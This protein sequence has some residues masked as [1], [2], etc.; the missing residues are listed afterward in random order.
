MADEIALLFA[1]ELRVELHAYTSLVRERLV[2]IEA[3][4]ISEAKSLWTIDERFAV[5]ASVA[6]L[7]LRIGA[8]GAAAPARRD[9]R[10]HLRRSTPRS[11]SR[12]PSAG[13]AP[14]DRR[15]STG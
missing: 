7:R 9:H 1:D 2:A 13:D 14:S 12:P 5:A 11:K 8:R 15:I 6:A 3:S 10:L 4:D